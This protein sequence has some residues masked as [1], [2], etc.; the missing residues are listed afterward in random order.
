MPNLSLSLLGS[1]QATLDGQPVTGFESNKVRALLAYLAVEADRPH[2]RDELIGLLWPDQPDATARANLRQ[3]LANLRHAIG[4]RTAATPFLSTTSDSIQFHLTEHGSIDAAAFSELIA[5]CHVHAHRRLET[6]RTCAQRLQQA[7]E[8]YRGDFLAQFVQSGSEAFEEWA[9]IQRER[10]HRDMLDALYALAEH[11]DRRSEYDLV[12]RYATRQLELDPWREEAQRQLMRAFALNRQRSA[13]LAQYETCRRVLAH[14]LGAEPSQETVALHAK[15]KADRLP[16]AD[17]QHNLP[18]ALTSLIG[19]KQERAEIDRLLE[20]STCRRLTLTGPG[21]IG[22]TRLALQAASEHVGL[23]ADGVWLVEL[24][25]LSDPALVLPA[26][27]PA[28]GLR[29]QG[30]HELRELLVDFLRPREV[31]LVLDNC[32]HLIEACAQ[33]VDDLTQACPQLSVLTTSREALKVAG[34][35]IFRV[36]PL[37][38]PDPWHIP[39]TAALADYEAVQL[40][41]ERAMTALPDFVMTDAHGTI[42]AQICHR[43]DGVPLA[44]ELAA[45]RLTTLSVEQ[46]AARLDDRLRLLTAGL[47]TALP[48]QQTLRATMD[49]SYD[50]LTG[51]ERILFRRLAVFAGS[52]T[53]EATEVVVGQDCLAPNKVL[54][55]LTHL[56]DKSLVVVTPQA[57]EV[58]YRMLE[59]IHEFACEKLSEADEIEA[60]RAHHLEFYVQFAEQVE[61]F[62]RDANQNQWLDRIE[63]EHDNLRAAFAWSLESGKATIGLHLAIALGDFWQRRSHVSEGSN[64]LGK[65]LP[66]ANPIS[67]PTLA[68]ALIQL[69]NLMWQQGNCQ[70]ASEFFEEGLMLCRKLGDPQRTARALSVGGKVAHAQGDRERAAWRLEESLALF[71]EVG[72]SDKWGTAIVLL[73]LADVRMRQGD[74]ERAALLCEESLDLFRELGDSWGIAFSLGTAGEMARRQGDPTRA[75]ALFAEA[76]KLHWELGN[77][78]NI[79]FSLEAL[80]IV[81]TVQGQPDRAA[82]LWGAAEATREATNTPVPSS[83]ENDYASFVEDARTQLTEPV[84]VAIWAEGRAMTLDQAIELALEQN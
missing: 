54:D 14:E 81:A 69:A 64:W 2:A 47:R 28:L 19:R 41:V 75:V 67:V 11:H 48:R 33:I 13:A 84:F 24:A 50:L 45:A 43:L 46:I 66:A 68:D 8:L 3:A 38:T 26:I 17:Q 34:E 58:R 55:G 70:Q 12:R 80:A 30:P 39:A 5:A 36:P 10:L 77:K 57:N 60:V 76:L 32:E 15:I 65:A 40:F 53:F 56:I 42:V 72:A 74:N 6:C 83:Y 44:I 35:V 78:V 62:L 73:W 51:D 20:T 49:W 25:A 37:T 4:D 18:M 31:L 82:R 23:F 7:V 79:P 27:A 9:L 21:G 61:P 22:K 63:A 71:R 29:E 16:H 52:W 1:F 59:T